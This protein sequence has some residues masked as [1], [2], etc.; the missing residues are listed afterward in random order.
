MIRKNI[1]SGHLGGHLRELFEE[2]VSAFRGWETGEPEPT[3]VL[4]PNY[5]PEFN[6]RNMR[7]QSKTEGQ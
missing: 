6:A 5:Q 1:R 4:E 3:L 7:L 2:A